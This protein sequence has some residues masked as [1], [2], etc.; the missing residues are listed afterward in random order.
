MYVCTDR[1]CPQTIEECE[2]IS[3]CI[4]RAVA[5]AADVDPVE[6]TPP[7]Y[8]IIDPE[9]LDALLKRCR[10]GQVQFPYKEWTVVARADGTVVVDDTAYEL[11]ASRTDV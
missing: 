3:K 5:D 2:T 1:M 11:P 8:E 7:I 6:L 9:A 4:V 10:Q